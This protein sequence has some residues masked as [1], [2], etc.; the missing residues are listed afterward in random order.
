LCDEIV[1][2][3]DLRTVN[4]VHFPVIG[5]GENV[6]LKLKKRRRTENTI[7]NAEDFTEEEEFMRIHKIYYDS[8]KEIKEGE[9][10]ALY[11]YL[12]DLQK[13]NDEETKPF[14]EKVC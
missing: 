10:T 1:L 11:D 8:I 6:K 5:V 7:Y 9:K 3:D 14:V 2:L 4:I 12:R 13:E